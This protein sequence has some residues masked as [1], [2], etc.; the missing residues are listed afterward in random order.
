[1]KTRVSV[2]VFVNDCL[3]KLFFASNSIQT[4]PNA[5][6]LTILVT[7]RTFTQF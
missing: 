6:F 2:K 5:I 3:W 4:P 1:M 7:L